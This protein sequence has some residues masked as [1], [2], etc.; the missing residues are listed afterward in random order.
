MVQSFR[1]L[2]DDVNSVNEAWTVLIFLQNT[3]LGSSVWIFLSNPQKGIS[4]VRIID[5]T[6]RN[7]MPHS[8]AGSDSKRISG[9]GPYKVSCAWTSSRGSPPQNRENICSTD[10]G[11]HPVGSTRGMGLVTEL[12]GA[13]APRSA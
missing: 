6:V 8:A 7:E 13:I 10:G 4:H 11:L 2:I 5:G 12:G 9:G 3:Y 1:L